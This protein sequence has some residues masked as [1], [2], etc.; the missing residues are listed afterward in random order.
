MVG[1][2][3]DR[4][5]KS[6]NSGIAPQVRQRDRNSGETFPVITIY[7]IVFFHDAAVGIEDN[8]SCSVRATRA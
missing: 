3:S 4:T 7:Y 2:F 5:A 6:Q 8:N 1:V